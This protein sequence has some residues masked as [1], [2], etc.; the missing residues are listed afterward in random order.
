LSAGHDRSK[1]NDTGTR[2]VCV[3]VRRDI[4]AEIGFRL[5]AKSGVL[6]PQLTQLKVE[7]LSELL[8]GFGFTYR[9]SSG[10][11]VLFRR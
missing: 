2:I 8:F 4:F 1:L 7:V 3:I 11:V 5:P 9:A 6:L 10:L